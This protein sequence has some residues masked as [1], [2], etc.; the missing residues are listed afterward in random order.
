[1]KLDLPLRETRIALGLTQS[2]LAQRAG[3][4]LATVQ[5]IEAGRANP[6]YSTLAALA[7]SLGKTIALTDRQLSLDS[8][9]PFGLPLTGPEDRVGPVSSG[10]LVPLLNRLAP[11]FSSLKVSTREHEAALAFLGALADHYPS[12]F[13]QLDRSLKKWTENRRSK[14]KPKLRRLAISQLAEYL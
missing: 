12:Y 10:Q 1:M 6:E 3:V 8:L 7:E 4:S 14:I 11:A 5:N 9:I 2:E 13:E